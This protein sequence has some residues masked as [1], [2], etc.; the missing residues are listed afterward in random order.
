[1]ANRTGSRATALARLFAQAGGLPA[2]AVGLDALARGDVLRDAA[3]VVNATS[4]G[5]GARRLAVRFA[6]A[7]RAC[8]FVDLVYGPR[9][10]PFLAGAARAGR[11]A[12]DGAA[13]LLHQ[14]ALAFEAWTGRPAP[15][16]AMAAALRAAGLRVGGR[17]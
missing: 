6:A 2:E 16:G 12:L 3:L 5:L 15:R 8:C 10:T 9:P 1:V 14:G 11:P 17:A 4:L 7:P 13:M